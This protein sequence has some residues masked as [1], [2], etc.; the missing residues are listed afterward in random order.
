MVLGVDTVT[1]HQK[2]V[3]REGAAGGRVW[4]YEKVSEL[5]DIHHTEVRHHILG[6]H[7]ASVLKTMNRT[8]Q[9]V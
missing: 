5:T 8:E 3:S 9:K 7:A 6:R 1:L 2:H 4:I